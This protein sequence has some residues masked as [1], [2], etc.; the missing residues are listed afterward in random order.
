MS[1]AAEPV[2]VFYKSK[3]CDHCIAL[4]NIWESVKTEMLK[5]NPRLRFFMVTCPDRRGQFD[6]NKAP[7]DLR[8]YAT[9]FPQILLVPGSVWDAGMINLGPK[10]TAEI[11]N[12]VQIFNAIWKNGVLTREVKYKPTPED[13]GRWIKASMD[14]PEFKRYQSESRA[15]P[16]NPV[17]IKPI[18][19]FMNTGF[20]QPTVPPEKKST[21]DPVIAPPH[22]GNI[23]SMRIVA[24]PR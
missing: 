22:L 16:T 19:P 18:Q 23:C 8:R 14:N 10:N 13:F 1:S 9:W 12:G 4:E 6:E 3:Q 7:K 17:A 21:N 20:H 5:V 24:R 2:V 15:N 11:K